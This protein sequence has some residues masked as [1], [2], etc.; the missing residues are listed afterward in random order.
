MTKPTP[1]IERVA[2]ALWPLLRDNMQWMTPADCPLPTFD[3]LGDLWRG[4]LNAAAAAAIEE[5]MKPSEAMI[6]AGVTAEH[7]KNLGERV[8]NEWQAMCRAALGREG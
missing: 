6:E 1:D 3:N 2:R 5:L 7:G 8:S 4:K